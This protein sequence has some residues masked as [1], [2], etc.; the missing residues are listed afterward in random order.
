MLRE[1]LD[2]YAASDGLANALR[3]TPND[4]REFVRPPLM[5]EG[6]SGTRW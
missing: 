4:I 6:P 5:R 3:V 1:A 2:R